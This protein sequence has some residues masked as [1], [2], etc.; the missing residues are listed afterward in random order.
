MKPPGIAVG[1]PP[2]NCGTYRL[3]PAVIAAGSPMQLADANSSMVLP[4]CAAMLERVSPG[5]M[6]IDGQSVRGVQAA[7]GCAA[8]VVAPVVAVAVVASVGS[9]AAVGMSVGTS[10][11]RLHA[12]S[13]RRISGNT[14][15]S[16]RL[17]QGR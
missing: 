7:V 13:I 12:R 10:P 9:G 2:G 11:P 17:E 16:G 5:A 1:T 3:C 4:T 6:V 8:I 15:H 14:S